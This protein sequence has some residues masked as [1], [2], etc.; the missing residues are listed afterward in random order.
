MTDKNHHPVGR[1]VNF[2]VTATT[3]SGKSATC[4]FKIKNREP[5]ACDSATLS[6][7][8]AGSFVDQ[9]YNLEGAEKEYVFDLIGMTNLAV[10][11]PD[12]DCGL[13]MVGL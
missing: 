6:F 12:I 9:T 2:S 10:S 13:Y 5:T 3:Q 4:N 8:P 1:V 11:D 7:D